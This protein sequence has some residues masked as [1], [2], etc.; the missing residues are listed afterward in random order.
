MIKMLK[1]TPS[2]HHSFFPPH[3]F[4]LQTILFP[5]YFSYYF[6]PKVLD[7]AFKVIFQNWALTVFH[8]G[9]HLFG[10]GGDSGELHIFF[11]S[12]VVSS[13]G[14]SIHSL[15]LCAVPTIPH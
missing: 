4:I 2:V 7:Q 14:P 5:L 9:D 11:C 6:F 10:L 15:P 3:F 12:V 13:I 8:K 1:C